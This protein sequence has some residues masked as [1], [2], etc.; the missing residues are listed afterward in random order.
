MGGRGIREMNVVDGRAVFVDELTP[1]QSIIDRWTDEDRERVIMPPAPAKQSILVRSD[2]ELLNAYL[3]GKPMVVDVEQPGWWRR[4]D[5]RLI[6]T[7]LGEDTNFPLS[8]IE[9]LIAKGISGERL[10]Y[11]SFAPDPEDQPGIPKDNKWL[12]PYLVSKGF[13]FISRS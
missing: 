11:W 12:K 2:R 9:D 6:Y 3:T 1:R 4:P 13:T 7:A 10:G 5:G 8:Y